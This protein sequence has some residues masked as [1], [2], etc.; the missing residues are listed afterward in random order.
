MMKKRVVTVFTV[1]S[2]LAVLVASGAV[3][4]SAAPPYADY[5]SHTGILHLN[6]STATATIQQ[7]TD[8]VSAP[9]GNRCHGLSAR[10]SLAHRGLC[11]CLCGPRYLLSSQI[12][13]LVEGFLLFSQKK[14][15]N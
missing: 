13:L 4:V 15:S 1:V 6:G 12:Q 10:F 7:I 14:R 9:G 3:S 5:D 11:G 2:I 8:A